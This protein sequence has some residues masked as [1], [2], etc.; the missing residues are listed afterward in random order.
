MIKKQGKL[1]DILILIKRDQLGCVILEL[2]MHTFL[3]LVRAMIIVYDT[4][5]AVSETRNKK[6]RSMKMQ[7]SWH[8]LLKLIH[9]GLEVS[10]FLSCWI[11]FLVGHIRIFVT[12]VLCNLSV[13]RTQR[14]PHV[15]IIL[16]WSVLNLRGLEGW[17]AT[18]NIFNITKCT[19]TWHDL[20]GCSILSQKLVRVNTF[21]TSYNRST[22]DICTN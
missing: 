5:H 10:F 17:I 1:L 6:W 16:K 12:L 20:R 21:L 11:I 8:D 18:D 2:S 13:G 19:S 15:F 14:Q 4:I 7:F 3:I 9:S 22:K